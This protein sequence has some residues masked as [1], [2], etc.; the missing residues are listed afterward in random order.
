MRRTIAA[1]LAV[2]TLSA[3]GPEVDPRVEDI[4]RE[5]PTLEVHTD[6]ELLSMMEQA[7]EDPDLAYETVSVDPSVSE[8]DHGYLLGIALATC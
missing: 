7:C 8:E 5:A 4:R 2:L 1:I 3:C 6:Q